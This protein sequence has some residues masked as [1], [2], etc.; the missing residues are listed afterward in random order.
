MITG[1]TGLLGVLGDPIGHSLSPAI[2]NAAFAALD[3]DL[4]YVPLPVKAGELGAALE[5]LRA[6]GFRGASVTIPHKVA[7][8][9]HLDRL[10]DDVRFAGAANTIVVEAGELCGYNTDVEGVRAP[11][12]AACGDSL[13]GEPGLLLGAGGAARAAAL[14]LA[15]LGVQLTVVNRTSAEAERLAALVAAAVPG[16]ECRWLPFSALT[17][18][19]L[20]S[21][22]LLF[23]ATSLGMAGGD[24]LP[25]LIAD[26][27]GREQVVFDSVYRLDGVTSLIGAARMHGAIGISGLEMLLAQGAAA[28]A[29][30]TGRC[31]PL[32]AM[33]AALPL[34]ETPPRGGI[35]EKD[36]PLTGWLGAESH[37]ER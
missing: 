25:A 14:A 20:A 32:A 19:L 1:T 7:V 9:A 29:L 36:H 30:W 21:Q 4:A 2:H 28:F 10:D 33:R 24:K 3:L 37:T 27:I 31:A 18:N 22:R 16:A 6:F 12:V 15:R 13:R 34:Q 35:K 17:A 5:G 8:L 23:N 26:T 11:L